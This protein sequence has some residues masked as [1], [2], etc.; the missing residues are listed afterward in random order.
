MIDEKLQVD[1]V[2]RIGKTTSFLDIST[3]EN[4]LSHF[5]TNLNGYSFD[6]DIQIQSGVIN[7]NLRV[8]GRILQDS[9]RE[10]KE[11]IT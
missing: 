3:G 2:V 4:N 7:G 8:N 11:N 5:K 9:S 6:K 10:L 1:G